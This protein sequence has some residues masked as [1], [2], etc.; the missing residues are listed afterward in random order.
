METDRN[1]VR[2]EFLFQYGRMQFSEERFLKN[3]IWRDKMKHP[4]FSAAEPFRMVKRF[5]DRE[6]VGD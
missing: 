2:K 5:M 4:S 1:W 3:W 6:Y